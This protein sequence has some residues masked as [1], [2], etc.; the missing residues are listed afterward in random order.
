MSATARLAQMGLALP[1]AAAAIAAYVPAVRTGNLLVVSGQLP[2]LDGKVLL[3]GQF[4]AGL[5]IEQG[6]AAARQS[7]L[8]LLA[9]VQAATGS[10][11]KV[12]RVIR[13]GGFIAS[14]PDFTDHAKVMN[15]ASEVME[16]VFGDNGR[17][18]RTTIGVPVLPLGAAV[19][20]EG[21]F[22]LAD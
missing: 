9:Q 12:R 6:Q 21:L 13:L 5:T 1:A 8:N 15:G 14:T 19:E 11:D 17:H 7:A 20:V 16:Q 4:G 3:T 2:L 10:L 22:E 18:A